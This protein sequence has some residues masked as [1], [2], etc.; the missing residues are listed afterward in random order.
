MADLSA[1]SSETF[2]IASWINVAI[3]ERSDEEPLESYLASLA[4]KLHI[5]SQDYTDQL[6]TGMVDSMMTMPRVLAEISQIEDTIRSL[7]TEMNSLAEQLSAFD[8]RNVAGVEDLS[9]LDT[10]KSNME[11]CKATLEE[12]ARWSQL[13]RESKA[14]ME[15]SDQIA[16]LSETADRIEIMFR[17]S[18][19]LKHLPG[20]DERIEQ[21]SSLRDTLLEILRPKVRRDVLG[22]D[23]SPL[24][25]EME[26]EYINARP[27]LISSSSIWDIS[28]PVERRSKTLESDVSALL[29]EVRDLMVEESERVSSLF[30]KE[31]AADVLCRILEQILTPIAPS[32]AASLNTT[33][34]PTVTIAVYQL[35][36]GFAK[37]MSV[38]LEGAS[39][40]S[41][42]AAYDS[43][44]KC[45]IVF[46]DSYIHQ[47]DVF[48]KNALK[49]LLESVNLQAIKAEIDADLGP[50]GAHGQDPY[51]ASICEALSVRMLSVTESSITPVSA[52][53]RRSAF[54]V[55]GLRVKPAL[56]RVSVQLASFVKGLVTKVEELR[57]ATG[58]GAETQLL[59]SSDSAS[60]STSADVTNKTKETFPGAVTGSSSLSSNRIAVFIPTA[61][62]A[63]QV[64]GRLCLRVG[65]LEATTADIL[66]VMYTSLYVEGDRDKV[67][68]AAAGLSVARRAVSNDTSLASELKGFLLASGR[69]SGTAAGGS[70]ST[71]SVFSPVIP[72]LTRLKATTASLLFD[73][74]TAPAVTALQELHADDVWGTG[75]VVHGQYNAE[76]N[77]ETQ[78]SLYESLLP[79]PAITQV[80]EHLLSL[81]QELE[82]FAS[83]DALD[84]LLQLSGESELLVRRCWTSLRRALDLRED[85]GVDGLCK[86]HSCTS[87]LSTDNKR[88][89]SSSLEAGNTE[90]YGED[91]DGDGEDGEV[92]MRF[93]NEWLSSISDAA[94]G[95]LVTQISKLAVLSPTG[96]SQLLVDLE[97]L[98]TVVNALGLCLHPLLTHISL[99]L[100]S[101]PSTFSDSTTRSSA[102]L[103]LQ[104]LDYG[105]IKAV[106][107]GHG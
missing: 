45:F 58:L 35:M 14:F 17:S 11:K 15:E 60:T 78:A 26:D 38:T 94:V 59:G 66:G 87:L 9:R 39:L 5:I 43:C 86:R 56:R 75:R 4:M 103:A 12:H 55:G 100:R 106:L 46:M 92:S 24:K 77:A 85:D 32:M 101:E 19:I 20:H 98:S 8:Q 53:I 97:Y 10:L 28:L 50:M 83:S 72:G 16:G 71:Q 95:L 31:R 18:D 93:V 49:T 76:A 34:D 68:K 41:L 69:A 6:E 48:V 37:K 90:D 99:L 36:E 30:G 81:V 70:T 23:L 25:N 61:L 3:K 22:S 42:Y 65:E 74:C 33:N 91:A 27:V 105:I 1:F 44:Y 40:A 67:S 51:D 96:R 21:C 54:F 2:D 73:L 47:E 88:P 13:V 29:T 84:D 64:A 52:A 107:C 79:Q 89:S 7:N 57:L 80:G 104:K 82:G 63:L 62:I 102:A